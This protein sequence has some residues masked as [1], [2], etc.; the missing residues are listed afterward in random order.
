MSEKGFS[1]IFI[2]TGKQF[3]ESSGLKGLVN[4]VDRLRGKKGELTG[5]TPKKPFTGADFTGEKDY[6]AKIK[7]P[8][9]YL[10]DSTVG[11]YS[12][13]PLTALGGIV[14]PYT[15]TISQEYSAV[16][17]T[18]N[19]THSNYSLYF[20]KH[21]TPSAI[22][23]SGKFSVQNDQEAHL[24]L[25]T[26]HLLRALTKMKF[27]F[28]VNAGNPPPVCRF[29]AYGD[30]QYKNVPVV[31]QSFRVELPDSVDY[32]AT[33]TKGKSAYSGINNMVPT[34]S[35]ITLS[36]LPMYSR[37]E[38]LGQSQVDDYLTGGPNLRQQGYL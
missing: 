25:G 12:G 1:D 7:V 35:Q 18:A 36:L 3:Y 30:M 14:F 19:P 29:F 24:W 34:V 37:R 20:Y 31:I 5:T 23:V 2:D 32:Y 10:T 15:P 33:T 8:T 6:R 27:G 9:S 13:S 17:N 28:D 11:P 38:L 16:Y 22:S 4:V 21:S 26:C